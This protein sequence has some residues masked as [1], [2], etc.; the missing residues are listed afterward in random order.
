MLKSSKKISDYIIMALGCF[1]YAVSVNLFFRDAHIA[2][3]GVT[4]LS[5]IINHIIPPLSVGTLMFLINI[6]LF[7]LG[8]K[9]IG[10]EFFK[11]TLY[12]TILLSIMLD[13]TNAFP[14]FTTDP[15]LASIYGGVLTGAGLGI[16]FLRGGS[17]GGADIAA[18]LL[19]VYNPEVS[20]GRIILIIDIVVIS[21]AALVFRDINS[22]L[23]AIITMYVASIV[24]DAIIY[25]TDVARV[26][27]IVTD[28]HDIINKKIAG[29]LERGATVIR[30]EGGYTGA[31]RRLILCAIKRNQIAELKKL[32]READ[33]GAFMIVTNTHE[34]LGHGFKEDAIKPP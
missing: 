11:Y 4:G 3:G 2:P 34:V 9:K 32:V 20:L 16:V 15:L 19:R 6:P 21:L 23:Y 24:M 33:P 8:F 17:T 30:C 31:E 12:A 29:A 5:L 10:G 14:A 26:A 28:S 1:L 7:I 22:A 27:Y 18:R 13:M 25:G